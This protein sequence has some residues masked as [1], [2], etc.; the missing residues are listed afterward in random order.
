MTAGDTEQLITNS[1]ER[2]DRNGYEVKDETGN[3]VV[4]LDRGA[5]YSRPVN[6][7]G[8]WTIDG[9][10]YYGFPVSWLGSN[11]NLDLR[12][13]VHRD[14]DHLQPGAE[15]DY[16]SLLHRRYHVGQQF[17]RPTR[18]YVYLPGRIQHRPLDQ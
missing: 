2:A 5:Q 7:N 14:A 17:Q 11:L 13:F 3:T 16:H 8:Y 6:L 15:H 1:V 9:G 4:V 18:L 12:G 10:A